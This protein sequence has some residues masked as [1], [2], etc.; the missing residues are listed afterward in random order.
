[1]TSKFKH[2]AN[3]HESC[4]EEIPVITPQASWIQRPQRSLS[5]RRCFACVMT[6]RV[7]AASWFKSLLSEI[8]LECG[9]RVQQHRDATVSK[10][11]WLLFHS[12]PPQDHFGDLQQ[13][14]R[15]KRNR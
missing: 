8:F 15:E 6:V 9:Q 2:H 13:L 14:S 11:K 7:A 4:Q 5:D 3:V 1:M 12:R 10:T